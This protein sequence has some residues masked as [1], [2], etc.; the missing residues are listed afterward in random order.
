MTTSTVTEWVLYLVFIA[1]RDGCTRECRILCISLSF[2]GQ[3][4]TPHFIA[5]GKYSLS[6]HTAY[7]R[8]HGHRARIETNTLHY[9]NVLSRLLNSSHHR[10]QLCHTW[11]RLRSI[12][13]A[14]HFK[15]NWSVG[16]SFVF[17]ATIKRICKFQQFPSMHTHTHTH[18]CQCVMRT[19]YVGLCVTTRRCRHKLTIVGIDYRR[20]K[21]MKMKQKT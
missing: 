5:F 19:T 7:T 21:M 17:S 13:K 12:D 16:R 3:C 1:I 11:N 15:L 9:F 8:T 20:I 10:G 6:T 14:R 2:Y 4:G 18:T